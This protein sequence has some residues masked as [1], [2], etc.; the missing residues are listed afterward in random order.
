[1]LKGQIFNFGSNAK[2]LLDG[3]HDGGKKKSS[4]ARTRS[5]THARAHTRTTNKVAVTS[6]RV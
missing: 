6:Q 5:T 4:R 1:M 2:E 3:L